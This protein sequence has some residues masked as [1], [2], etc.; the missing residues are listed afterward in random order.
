MNLRDTIDGN[1]VD[2][3]DGVE[4]VILRRDVDVIHVEQDAAIRSMDDLVKELPLR[5]LG[6]MKFRVAA[7][8]F[9]GDRDFEEVLNLTDAAG[10]STN[11]LEGVRQG[12]KIVGIAAV[13]AS[14][15]KVVGKPRGF[16]AFR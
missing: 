13:H 2:I 7:D 12:K 4:A 9:D 3:L 8:V 14:P 10:C 11:G 5:H 6:L 16:S 15:A 1:A